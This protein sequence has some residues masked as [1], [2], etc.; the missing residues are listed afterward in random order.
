MGPNVEEDIGNRLSVFKAFS[1][2]GGG[3]L[4]RDLWKLCR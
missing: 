4:R 1:S 2:P 3:R